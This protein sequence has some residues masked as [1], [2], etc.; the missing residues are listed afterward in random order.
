MKV[1]R[2]PD[3][4]EFT[5]ITFYRGKGYRH[6]EFGRKKTELGMKL[7]KKR[8]SVI[9]LDTSCSSGLRNAQSRVPETAQVYLKNDEPLKLRVFIDRS[10]VEVFVNG[11]QCV[12]AR[13]Y[14]GRKDS[15][16]VS[17]QARGSDAMI[18]SFDAW[19]MK[20]IYKE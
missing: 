11:K 5:R 19:Q 20:N 17:F 13:V 10:V 6:N 7:A 3:N 14:P 8:S 15:V 1:L 4:E 18:T 12:A 16:G 2:S 9:S